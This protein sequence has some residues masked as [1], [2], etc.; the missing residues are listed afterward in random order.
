MNK[1]VLFTSTIIGSMLFF[2]GCKQATPAATDTPPAETTAETSD[3]SMTDKMKEWSDAI[4][5]GG[6]LKCTFTDKTTGAVSNYSAK[7]N[8][9]HMTGVENGEND[10]NS[11]IIS[12]SEYMYTWDVKKKEG[13]KL[14][15]P[16]EAELKEQ[17]EKYKDMTQDLPDFTNPAE[18]KEM[19]EEGV[20][21]NCSPSV[22]SDAEFVPPKD[23]KFQDL[24]TMMNDAMIKAQ[25]GMTDEQKK[26]MEDVLKQYGGQ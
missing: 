16:T 21:T 15:M 6:G 2:A 26:Q 20:T 4:K 8:K 9:F 22:I 18:V 12:D 1:K 24:N 7:G 14:K 3:A 19:E 25:E 17:A 11:E 10:S 23:V 13:V 5:L